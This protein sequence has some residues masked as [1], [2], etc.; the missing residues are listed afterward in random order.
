MRAAHNTLSSL[1]IAALAACSPGQVGGPEPSSC[2][3]AAQ[4]L[5]SCLG[6]DTSIT[7]ITGTCNAEQQA[8]AQQVL[9]T[10]CESLVPRST[11]SLK[12]VFC[13]LLPFLCSDSGYEYE[14]EG[15][16]RI[17][18]CWNS[19]HHPGSFCYDLVR[20]N[21]DSHCTEMMERWEWQKDRYNHVECLQPEG[22][23][24]R[25]ARVCEPFQHKGQ[26]VAQ[27]FHHHDQPRCQ[28]NGGED[29]DY[30]HHHGPCAPH[31][32]FTSDGTCRE[33]NT[34]GHHGS[35]NDHISGDPRPD[36]CHWGLSC[37]W[38]PDVVVDYG[39]PGAAW[40]RVWRCL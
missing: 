7:S 14:H 19:P 22:D 32:V 9:A 31:Q 6:Q 20:I 35:C 1:T 17:N 30:Y 15:Y 36:L 40:V 8:K 28:P 21:P 4:H 5:A 33:S 10:P 3:S 37:S 27:V 18:D 26:C 12:D 13:G 23:R 2:E 39:K 25:L 24:C 16:Y 38:T 11:M 34:V 29:P